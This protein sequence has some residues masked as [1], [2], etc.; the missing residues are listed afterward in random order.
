MVDISLGVGG[1]SGPILALDNVTAAPTLSPTSGGVIYV[2]NGALMYRGS[3]G[4]VTQ[5]ALA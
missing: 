5:L 2:E 3:S 1:S 4:T